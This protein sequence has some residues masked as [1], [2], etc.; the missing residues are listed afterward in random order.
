MAQAGLTADHAPFEG[1]H[2]F[3]DLMAGPDSAGFGQALKKLEAQP[4]APT[5]GVWQKRYPCCAS[6]HRPIDAVLALMQEHHLAPHDILHIDAAVSAA[7]VGNLMYTHPENVMQAR[8]SMPYCLAAAALDGDVTLS[9]FTTPALSRS[10]LMAFLPRITMTSDPAQPKDMPATEKSWAT[11]TIKTAT[12]SFTMKVI[13]PK[14]YPQN[15]L[16]EADL[17]AKF[18]DCVSYAGATRIPVGYAYWRSLSQQADIL[19]HYETLLG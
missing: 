18:R 15:P 4:P 14:G 13:D 3:R 17:E 1:E 11:V 6:T 9:T 16:T 5:P 2:G 8:F 7:A 12:R 10:D 19:T